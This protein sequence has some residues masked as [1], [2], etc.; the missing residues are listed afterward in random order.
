MNK[1]IGILRPAISATKFTLTCHAPAPALR[2]FVERYWIV[3]WDLR[4]QAPH[5]Q[6]TLP[7][8][9][10][11][12]AVERG[13]SRVF[14]VITGKFSTLLENTG[15]VFGIKFK[16]GAFFPFVQSSVSAL[17]DRSVGLG[18]LFGEAGVALEEAI[19]AQ[20]DEQAM[21]DRAEQFLCA[22]L[23]DQDPQVAFISQIVDCII[24][25][26]AIT[27]VDEIATLFDINKR[28]LQRLFRQYV[29]VSPK[30]VIKRYRLQEAADRLADGV[31]V[32]WPKLAVDLGYF[33]QAH[34]IKDFRTIVSST[35]VEYVR[36]NTMSFS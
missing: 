31:A 23:P 6:E 14:G 5:V 10:V 15:M 19:L 2:Y 33:D 35:P 16:P 3:S 24:G 9:C 8:P 18:D 29:G 17:T 12:L 28:R 7:H 34:F 36:L 13:K 11:N 21:I 20:T 27:K 22:R 4:G 32:D 1:P 25:N 26:H 30:W